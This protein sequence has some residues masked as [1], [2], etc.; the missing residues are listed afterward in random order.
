[1]IVAERTPIG[2]KRFTSTTEST[3]FK[4]AA[5]V[6]IAA[7][8]RR[9]CVAANNAAWLVQMEYK[10]AQ[11]HIHHSSAK[12]GTAAFPAHKPIIHRPAKPNNSDP[13]PTVTRVARITR[14]YVLLIQ[15]ISRSRYA[16]ENA[17][18]REGTRRDCNTET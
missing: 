17:G 10:T 14:P 7:C 13:T 8:N 18:Q 16:S 12:P 5:S 2:P 6:P 11:K 3:R 9:R 15:T 1:M 4:I